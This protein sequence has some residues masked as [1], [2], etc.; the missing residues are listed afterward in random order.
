M[1]KRESDYVKKRKSY[2][3]FAKNYPGKIGATKYIIGDSIDVRRKEIIRR[4]IMII[5]AVL[6]FIITFVVTTVGIRISERPIQTNKKAVCSIE[7]IAFNMFKNYQYI[8]NIGDVKKAQ[9]V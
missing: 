3:G 9:T 2:Y 6:L 1:S 8:K 5:L 4:I 7:H